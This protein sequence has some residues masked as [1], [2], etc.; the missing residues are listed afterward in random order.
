[1]PKQKTAQTNRAEPRPP[2]ARRRRGAKATG[3]EHAKQGKVAGN[4][5]RRSDHTAWGASKQ[6][7]CLEL[8]GRPEGACVEEL[9]AATGWKAHSVSGFLSGTVKTKLGLTLS[10]DRSGDGPRHYR[11]GPE[12]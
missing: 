3:K 4:G 7:L 10:S 11:I 6:Q 1:M 12:A 8:L 5:R 9:Q 2:R